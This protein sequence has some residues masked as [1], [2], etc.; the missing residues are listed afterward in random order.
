M[1]LKSYMSNTHMK[2]RNIVQLKK[3]C[4]EKLSVM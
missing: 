1:N 2:L 4:M 3:L